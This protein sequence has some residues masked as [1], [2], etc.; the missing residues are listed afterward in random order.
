MAF[1]I[2]PD[3]V[4]NPVDQQKENLFLRLDP[5]RG[6]LAPGGIGGDHHIA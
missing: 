2:V 5:G 6:S 4:K 3:Q 1:V